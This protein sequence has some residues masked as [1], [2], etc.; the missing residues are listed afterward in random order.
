MKIGEFAKL[1][2]A[3]IRTLRYYDDLGLLKPDYIDPFTGY[4]IYSAKK[5][6]QMQQ[7]QT[8]KEIGFTLMEIKTFLAINDSDDN[9]KIDFIAAKK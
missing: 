8:M 1:S 3:T 4:R 6:E 5:L 9:G 7:I 2:S